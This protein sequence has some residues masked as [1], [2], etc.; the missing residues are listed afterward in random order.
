MKIVL[1]ILCL[2]TAIYCIYFPFSYF[3]QNADK[4]EIKISHILVADK[5]ESLKIK[6]SIEEEGKSF[7]KAA[8][9][10]SIWPST[11]NKGNIGYFSRE[12]LN[13]NI[14][15]IVDYSFKAPK[16]KISEPIHS[17]LGWHLVKIYDIKY[18]SDKENFK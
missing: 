13:A 15:E 12:V 16:F 8:Q 1:K 10:K 2:L 5:E 7:E 14:P 9:E 17:D 18:Y 3:H 4:K 6:K 11:K